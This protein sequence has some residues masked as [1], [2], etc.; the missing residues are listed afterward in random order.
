M[1]WFIQSCVD[2]MCGRWLLDNFDVAVW[3]SAQMQN[4]LPVV[5][6]IMGDKF[7]RW[8]LDWTVFHIRVCVSRVY[9]R[10]CLRAFIVARHHVHVCCYSV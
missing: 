1:W 4:I 2:A 10:V 8:A 6:H 7:S 5:K 9:V 3:S